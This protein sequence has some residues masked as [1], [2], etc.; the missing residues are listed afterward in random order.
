[1]DTP[2]NLYVVV[3]HKQDPKRPWPNSWLDDERLDWITTTAEIGQ[4]CHEALQRGA[5]VF[6]HRCGWDHE[7][8]TVCCSAKI[9]QISDIDRRSSLVTFKDQ[10]VLNSDPPVTPTRG[11]NFYFA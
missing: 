4:H 1:M 11:Q 8:P 3:H 7:K 6:V 10:N 2:K 5:A 9:L